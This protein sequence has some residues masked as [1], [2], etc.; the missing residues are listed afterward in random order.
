[1]KI[2]TEV[3]ISLAFCWGWDL[4]VSRKRKKALIAAVAC[5][6]EMVEVADTLEG[7][8]KYLIH[9]LNENNIDLDEFD[10]IALPHVTKMIQSESP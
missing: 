9:I 10:L 1:M 6:R 2:P 5:V 7:E 4:A 8:L 3:V